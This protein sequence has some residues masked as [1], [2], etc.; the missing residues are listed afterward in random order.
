MVRIRF[1]SYVVLAA[2]GAFLVVATQAF[3]PGVVA[4][5]TLGVSIGTL[6]ASAGIAALF[7]NHLAS[8]VIG[9][10][11]AV[12]SAFMIVASQVFSLTV[13]RDLAFAEG[14][15]IAALAVAGLTAHELST[16]RVVH[17]LETRQPHQGVTSSGR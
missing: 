2:T 3:S 1:A 16:E 5:L 8:L 4:S 7:R 9:I 15:A 17:T 13:V 10:Y 6:T 11:G 12:F 14:L